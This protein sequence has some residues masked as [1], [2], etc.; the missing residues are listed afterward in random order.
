MGPLVEKRLLFCV[1]LR[2]L[3][4]K[5]KVGER[6]RGLRSRGS[7]GQVV[8]GGIGERHECKSDGVRRTGRNHHR[9]CLGRKPV[10]RN[11]NL[12]RSR[13]QR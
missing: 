7:I 4:R 6:R 8:A 10:G 9:F 2:L 12:I 11:N 13:L 1:A 3:G 5:T